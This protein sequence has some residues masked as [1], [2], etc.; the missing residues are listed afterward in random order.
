MCCCSRAG[1]TPSATPEVAERGRA[2]ESYWFV[3]CATLPQH[4][5]PRVSLRTHACLPHPRIVQDVDMVEV[6][7][8]A[9]ES[10]FRGG[11]SG[12]LAMFANGSCYD[13]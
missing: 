4:Q 3:P 6:W 9:K 10:A 8:Q 1:V 12:A 11:I 2:H 7:I 13:V 5:T